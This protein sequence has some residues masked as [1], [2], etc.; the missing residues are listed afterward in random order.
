MKIAIVTETFL[1]STDGIVTRLCATVRWLREQ[2]HHVTVIAPDLGVYEYDGV[3]IEGIPARPFFLYPSK[4]LALPSPK[5]GALLER[6][7]PDLVHVVNPAVL[8]VA[9]IYYGRKLKLPMI[10]SYHT[11]IPKYADYYRLPF[12]KPILWWWFRLLHNR[13]DVNLCTSQSVL[14]ELKGRKFRSVH[15]WKRGVDVERFGPG[16]RHAEMRGLLSGGRPDRTVLLYV[17]RLAAEKGIEQIREA[18]E[19]SPELCLALVGDG[20]HRPSLERYFRGTNTVFTGFL[21]GESLAEA[22]ASADLF[23]FPST[24]ETLGL[25]ILEAMASGLPVVA[26]RSG[27]T[28]E[29]IEDG[30]TGVLFDGDRPEALTEAIAS[31][32]EPGLRETISANAYAA[33]GRVGWHEP[34]EQLLGFYEDALLEKAARSAARP[35][36]LRWRQERRH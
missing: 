36:P 23:V 19:A 29:Q 24:T 3:K 34:S 25:V 1:P 28:C 12:L 21:H 20:P 13:A 16:H 7:R 8:G 9:G 31:L 11:Q 32:S 22:Y 30:V 10:A 35:F 26:G 14:D 6:L 33:A 17:G 2:G 4:R 27:P 15:L 5:V 18:L